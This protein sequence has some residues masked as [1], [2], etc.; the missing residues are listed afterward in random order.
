MCFI[1]ELRACFESQDI[2]QL[3]GVIEKMEPALA[4]KHMKRCVASGL[5]VPEGGTNKETGLNDMPGE[6]EEE[7]QYD[8]PIYEPVK[9]KVEDTVD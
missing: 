4:A 6:E 8:E 5:W 2:G 9:D 1:Q 7:E 3:K